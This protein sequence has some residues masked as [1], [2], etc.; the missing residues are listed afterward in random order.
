MTIEK[1]LGMSV[2]ELDAMSTEQLHAYFAPALAITRPERVGKTA[3]TKTVV[4]SSKVNANIDLANA[5]LASMGVNV[6]L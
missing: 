2:A 5:M 4:N 3:T 6:K 1:Y